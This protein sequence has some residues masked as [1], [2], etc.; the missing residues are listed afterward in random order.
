MQADEELLLLEAL[1]MYGLGNWGAVG[2]HVN[3]GAAE[4]AAHYE[5]IYLR[6]PAFPEPTPAP[7]MAGVRMTCLF[8]PSCSVF[9]SFLLVCFVPILVLKCKGGAVPAYTVHPPLF[10]GGHARRPLPSP[11]L[12]SSQLL[13]ID[14]A[15]WIKERQRS[16]QEPSEPQA[17][18]AARTKADSS[19]AG[20]DGKTAAAE[21]TKAPQQQNGVAAG[22]AGD[23]EMAGSPSAQ[24]GADGTGG[25]KAEPKAEP[26]TQPHQ[27]ANTA[28]ATDSAPGS[29]RS[30]DADVDA[31]AGGADA[32]A[33][34]LDAVK[35]EDDSK[36]QVDFS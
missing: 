4:C 11:T 8:S 21:L 16:R 26:A 18:A 31:A 17:Q 36:P 32:A 20:A 5:R 24:G 7:E 29:S 23:E 13:Q 27:A 35:Q 3:R 2:E 30:G 6:S 19:A 28:A 15:A 12:L 14:P 1:D 22:S 10:G 34:H 25:V 33:S 9:V